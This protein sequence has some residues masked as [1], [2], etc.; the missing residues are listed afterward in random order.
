MCTL[1]PRGK[2]AHMLR[3]LVADDD[4]DVRAALE[5][6]LLSAGD[7]VFLAEHDRQAIHAAST[8]SFDEAMVDS[9]IPPPDRVDVL[10]ALRTLQP[11]CAS[12]LLSGELNH[13]VVTDAVSRG[14][15]SRILPKPADA[16]TV[17][18]AIEDAVA[19]RREQSASD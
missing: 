6:T 12:V 8:T 13:P 3:V 10:A 14:D 9:S 11:A 19:T 16:A 1:E 15:I 18:E 2:G 17:L 5:A 7:Q 4:P